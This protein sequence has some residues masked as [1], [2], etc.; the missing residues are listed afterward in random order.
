MYFDRY[1][2]ISNVF[3]WRLFVDD[4][5]K[6][7]NG[8]AVLVYN[9]GRVQKCTTNESERTRF[10]HNLN[11]LYGKRLTRLCYV[12]VGD[13]NFVC[14]QSFLF[15][16]SVKRDLD[17]TPSTQL[18]GRFNVT[19][20]SPNYFGAYYFVRYITVLVFTLGKFPDRS[21]KQSSD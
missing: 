11:A 14:M 9:M 7:P 20:F 13:L 12:D 19:D 15:I 6:F 18:S 16:T 3:F 2:R 4:K 10:A 1:T 17:R 8:S 5:K 21:R